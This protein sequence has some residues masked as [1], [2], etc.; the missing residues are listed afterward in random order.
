MGDGAKGKSD[1]PFDNL[2]ALEAS[3]VDASKSAIAKLVDLAVG[4]VAE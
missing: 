3:G 4:S 1:N 2:D